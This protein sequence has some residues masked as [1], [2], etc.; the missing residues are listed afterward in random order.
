MS[1]SYNTE[2]L[3][4]T[5]TYSAWLLPYYIMLLDLYC[6]LLYDFVL[7]ILITAY[8]FIVILIFR[9]EEILLIYFIDIFKNDIF[10]IYMNK[11]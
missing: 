6:L 4:Y 7:P 3:L 1:D 9:T 2:L 5:T 8:R 10:K 11:Y